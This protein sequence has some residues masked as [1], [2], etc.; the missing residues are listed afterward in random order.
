M[1][2]AQRNKGASVIAFTP[3]PRSM[4][5]PLLLH[6]QNKRR[7]STDGDVYDKYAYVLMAVLPYSIHIQFF[8]QDR[9]LLSL[10]ENQMI[11]KKATREWENGKQINND[12][13]DND[14]DGTATTT[15]Q[16]LHRSV[17]DIE[18]KEDDDIATNN[19]IAGGGRV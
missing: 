2:S 4:L 18:D 17:D 7:H 11:I 1:V 9:S 12:D 19:N 3:T 16:W 13:K 10:I 14:D 8:S 5:L 6:E 15:M